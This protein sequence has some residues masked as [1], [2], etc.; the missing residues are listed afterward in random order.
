MSLALELI[1]PDWSA[2]SSVR[3]VVTTRQGGVSKP[4]FDCLNLASHVLDEI[5]DVQTNRHLL[6]SSLNCAQPINWL[7]QVHS[8]DVVDAPVATGASADAVY[9]QQ[10]GEIC[11]VLTADCLP[12]LFCNK[13]GIEVAAAH[14]GWKGLFNGVLEATLA[15]FNSDPADIMCW[16]GP[17]IG[18]GQF[19]VGNDVL[20]LAIL[21]NADLKRCFELQ[22]NGKYLLDIYLAARLLLTKMGI[23]SIS[24]G[25][26]CTV[27]DEA[28]FYSYRRDGKTGRMASLI[29]IESLE[30]GNKV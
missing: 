10:A 27:T 14:A 6:E 30:K 9:S 23:R 7:N 15:R 16:L 28:R 5:M 1:I 8:C 29:W 12:V 11:A 20:E 18:A 3:S 24:G 17:A 22:E 26:F 21:H 19:E 2:P 13:Q 4:P 25:N